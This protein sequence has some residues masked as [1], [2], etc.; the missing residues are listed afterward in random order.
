MDKTNKFAAVDQDTYL[1][2]GAKHTNKELVI[3]QQEAEAI[4]GKAKGHVSMWIKML[5]M[6]E[7][8]GHGPRIRE[9][10]I[11]ESCT[12]PPMKLLVK[13]HN[14]LPADGVPPTLTVV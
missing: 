14:K 2:M 11:Q 6:R 7:A 1:K 8:H 4:Q 12:V 5:G 10:L 9:S 3:S 13:D